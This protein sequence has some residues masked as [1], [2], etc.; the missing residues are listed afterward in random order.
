MTDLYKKPCEKSLVQ[1]TADKR[2]GGVES[3]DIV[4]ENTSSQKDVEKA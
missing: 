3:N 1:Q 2:K 4:L